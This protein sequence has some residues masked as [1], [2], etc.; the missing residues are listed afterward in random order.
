MNS[1][2]KPI[3]EET[4]KDR[5]L[6]NRTPNDVCQKTSF[7][8]KIQERLSHNPQLKCIRINLMCAKKDEEY[9][10]WED[11]YPKDIKK[12]R[13]GCENKLME[14]PGYSVWCAHFQPFDLIQFFKTD[15][16]EWKY[17]L[18][19]I[20]KAELSCRWWKVLTTNDYIANVIEE[21]KAEMRESGEMTRRIIAVDLSLGE[22]I[23]GQVTFEEKTER[24]IDCEKAVAYTLREQEWKASEIDRP[25]ERQVV[26]TFIWEDI[27][28]D[29]QTI[30]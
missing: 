25:S 3:N 19:P 1:D 10:P 16:L 29:S 11:V 7:E 8:K 27:P 9:I 2:A 22:I 13:R 26:K 18:C 17:R 5:I 14:M 6:R 20:C 21:A 30:Y 12:K 24:V 28:D 15:R 4:F 23:P